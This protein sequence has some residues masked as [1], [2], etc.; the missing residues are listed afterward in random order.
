MKP[1]TLWL[2]NVRHHRR[3]CNGDALAI[4]ISVTDSIHDAGWVGLQDMRDGDFFSYE[5]RSRSPDFF[6]QSRAYIVT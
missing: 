5:L 1:F 2:N 3:D 6:G 4:V